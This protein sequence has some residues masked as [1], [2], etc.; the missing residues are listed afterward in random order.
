MNEI[1]ANVSNIASIYS[2]MKTIIS[3]LENRGHMDSITDVLAKIRNTEETELKKE[4]EGD[5]ATFDLCS[6]V[7]KENLKVILGIMG[8]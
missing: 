4:L 2:N 6:K 5:M 1:A 3:R 8:N 7:F